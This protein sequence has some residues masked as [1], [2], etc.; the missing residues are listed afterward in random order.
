MK[1]LKQIKSRINTISGIKKTTKAMQ[2]ISATKL[3]GLKKL[4]SQAELF[5]NNAKKALKIILKQ[6]K[7]LE[8]DSDNILEK[9]LLGET[10]LSQ[11]AQSNILIISSNQGLCGSFN[12]QLFKFINE[13][14]KLL[15]HLQ[16]MPD[17]ITFGKKACE[18]YS[19][20]IQNIQNYPSDNKNFSQA[21]NSITAEIVNKI[22]N[23]KS[24]EITIYSNRFKNMI[25]NDSVKISVLEELRKKTIQEEPINQFSIESENLLEKSFSMYL[26]S[27]IYYSMIS[28]KLAEESSRVVSMDSASK[29]A[30]KAIESLTLIMNRARQAMVT[31]ELIEI[32]TSAELL[33]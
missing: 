13:D 29:N 15:S 23:N 6:Y 32:T 21:A 10:K 1:N 19:R 14:I 3:S 22:I 27:L 20:N 11:K 4:M 2:L 33:Q 28:S 9:I 26:Y 5:Y 12:Q 18:F 30:N 7:L 31:K 17:V 8:I 24:K 16:E 25:T